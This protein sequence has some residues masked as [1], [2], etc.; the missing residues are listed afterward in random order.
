MFKGGTRHHSSPN[1]WPGAGSTN[2]P[3]SWA[4]P[5]RRGCPCLVYFICVFRW[6]AQRSA[7]PVERGEK[8]E[9][10]RQRINPPW[11]ARRSLPALER[12]LPVNSW[13]REWLAEERR[14]PPYPWVLYSVYLL[15]SNPNVIPPRLRV[16]PIN[17]WSARVR[18]GLNLAFNP[19]FSITSIS[20]TLAHPFMSV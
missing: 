5:P 10:Q 20:C 3:S 4:P 19:L 11:D 16:W 15:G 2:P 17:A 18:K 6:H 1:P 7:A 12:N 14:L 9:R 8:V 13:A